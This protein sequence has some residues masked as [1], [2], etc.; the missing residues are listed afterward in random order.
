MPRAVDGVF[1]MDHDDKNKLRESVIARRRD[2]TIK[3]MIATPPT[4][5]KEAA[6]KSAN[7]TRRSLQK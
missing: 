6:K 2:A 7:G 1:D 3:A 5:H 4:P